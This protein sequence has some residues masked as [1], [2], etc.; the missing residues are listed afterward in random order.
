VR[1]AAE[2]VI[3]VT[4][5]QQALDLIGR[6]LVDPHDEVLVEEPCYAGATAA[7]RNAGARLVPVRV[8]EQGLDVE[9]GAR[10]SP[11]ARLCYVTPSH[12]FP[13]GVTMS[14]ARRLAL[15]AWAERARAWIVEDDYD[16][17]FRYTGHPL[18]ALQGLDEHA[19][20]LYVGTLNKAMFPALRLAYLV[21]PLDLVEPFTNARQW[22]DGFTPA[23]T[24][25][26]MADF[27]LGGHFV[28]HT[29]RMRAIYHERRDALRAAVER[30]AVDRIRLGPADGG[31]HAVGWLPRR[32]DVAQLCRRAAQRN[33]YLR[34]LGVYYANHSPGPGVLLNF[35][36]APERAIE[37]GIA[38][39]SRLIG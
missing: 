33:M 36:S 14:L 21:V 35:A 31:M 7:F 26:V 4:S 5:T 38:A 22:L 16:S 25:A 23:G 30:H 11:T 39:V 19:R 3:V 18:A 2:Q 15:L 6:L 32:T 29:R 10:I 20:V 28:Q 1:C 9:H 13:L 27:M 24:Q 8:D 34:D 12:Q 37:R 17:E